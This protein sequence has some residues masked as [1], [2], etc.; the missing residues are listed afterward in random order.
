MDRLAAL[1]AGE[2]AAACEAFR[3]AC[4]EMGWVGVDVASLEE[5]WKRGFLHS[6][7]GNFAGRA[8]RSVGWVWQDDM[9]IRFRTDIG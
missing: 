2:F 3:D 6:L 5:V 1:S 4:Y 7:F 8:S 9:L